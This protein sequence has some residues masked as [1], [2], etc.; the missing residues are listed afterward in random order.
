MTTAPTEISLTR[1][2]SWA[3]RL[4][5]WLL[6]AATAVVLCLAYGPMLVAYFTHQWERPHY[7]YFPFVIGAFLWLLWRNGRQAEPRAEDATTD[8][9][10]AVI[11]LAILSWGLLAQSHISDSPFLAIVSAI[12]LAAALFLQIDARWRVPYLWGIW[13]LLWLV[14]RPPLNYDQY[15]IVRLQHLSSRLASIYLDSAGVAHLMEGN[16]LHLPEKEF[17]VDEACSGIV[18][19]L[20]IIACS[21]IYGVWRNRPPLHVLLLALA[22]VGWATLMNVM[23]ITVIALAFHRWGVDWS[24]G[25]SHEILGLVIFT[26]VFLAL[27]CT[28]YLLLALLAPIKVGESVG[29]PIH[30][31]RKV[32]DFWDWLGRWGAPNVTQKGGQQ[33][34]IAGHWWSMPSRLALGLIPLLAFGTLAAAQLTVPYLFRQGPLAIKHSVERAI[35]LDAEVL[36]ASIGSLQRAGFTE[37]ER[38]RDDIF[39]QYSR[40]Y[41]YADGQGNAY[42]FSCDFPFGPDWHDLTVCYRGIGW[43]LRAIN[44]RTGPETAGPSTGETPWNYLECEFT[45]SDGSAGWLVY[46]VFDEFGERTNPPERSFLK[47]IWRSLEKKHR[48]AQKTRLFQVQV[49]TEAVGTVRP[50]QREA[51]EKLLLE[52]R[53]RIRKSVSQESSS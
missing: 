24:S 12:L 3:A 22:G 27:V 34:G 46:S 47:D 13:A 38:T 44:V 51:A 5:A 9:R 48:H 23:R 26:I 11:G 21:A 25:T 53:E 36:P 28:D 15:L 6:P 50:A 32:V 33:R 40:T 39:G 1:S 52:A 41:A 2:Q 7:Q 30:F 49:W 29:Q 37:Q 20:S 4:P 45:K 43:E 35:A 31:G 42:T 16:R 14:V 10:L 17:F 8:R 18:S 19:V